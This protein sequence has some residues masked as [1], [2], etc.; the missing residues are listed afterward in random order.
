M[1]KSSHL[2]TM[3]VTTF[4]T[5]MKLHGKRPTCR[6]CDKVIEVKQKYFSSSKG[7]TRKFYHI[8]CAVAVN[9]L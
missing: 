2:C 4:A 7:G 3:S 6:R 1:T 9:L 5:I 8:P